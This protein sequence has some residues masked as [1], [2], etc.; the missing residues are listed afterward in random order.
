MSSA[1]MGLVIF[2]ANEGYL[3]GVEV[4]KIRSFETALLS[5]ANSQYAALMAKINVKGDYNDEIA[6]GLKECIET[7]KNTQ[8]W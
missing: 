6:A 4:N 5:Y 2:A 8:A 7:F 3:K 1:E